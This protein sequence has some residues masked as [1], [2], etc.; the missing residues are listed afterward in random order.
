MQTQTN[1]SP[2]LAQLDPDFCFWPLEEKISAEVAVIGGGIAGVSTLAYLMKYTQKKVVLL[3]G[4]KIAHGA[5]G[6]NAGQVVSYFE[7]PFSSIVSEYG[8]QKAVDAQSA[9]ISAWD[10]LEELVAQ[11]KNKVALETFVGYAALSSLEQLVNH[12]ENKFLRDATGVQFD[13]VFIDTNWE[14]KSLIPERFEP[15]ITWVDSQY[16]RERV[17]TNE[18]FP[19][20]LAS[21]KGCTNSALLCQELLKV[22]L[23]KYP[24]RITIYENTLVTEARILPDK[25]YLKSASGSVIAE[26]IILCTNGYE[27]I[28]FVD[29]THRDADLLDRTFH[30]NI[31]GLI[32]YMAGYYTEDYKP[33]NAVSYFVPELEGHEGEV[34]YFYLTRRTDTQG[35][36]T[37]NLIVIGGPEMFIEDTNEYK[38]DVHDPKEAFHDI[39]AFLKK[40]RLEPLPEKMDYEWHGLMGFTKTRLRYIGNT[41]AIPHV[42]YNLGCNGVGILS[43][44]YGGWKV[45]QMMSGT[46]FPPSVFDIA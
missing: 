38:F 45:A 44:V 11:T 21:K 31:D 37:R 29:E 42:W 34:S 14:E 4:G 25:T 40:Y 41:Q 32:G 15:L 1:R 2:W 5:S 23:E 46:L 9:I 33:A 16:I 8:M 36:S 6:H 27:K 12:L 28:Q 20:L 3:E 7:R 13:V 17:E 35:G 22:L 43:S 24:N 19:I 10:L 18:Y 30:K 26:H 39:Q